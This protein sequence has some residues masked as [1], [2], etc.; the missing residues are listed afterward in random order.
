M[1]PPDKCRTFLPIII[2]GCLFLA[3]PVL[4]QISQIL[5]VAHTGKLY[6]DPDLGSPA[7]GQALTGAEAAVLKKVGDWYK[8]KVGELTGWLPREALHDS[9]KLLHGEPVQERKTEDV[10]IGVY[11]KKAGPAA[12]S[13]LLSPVARFLL[14]ER[15]KDAILRDCLGTAISVIPLACLPLRME[16]LKPQQAIYQDPDDTGSPLVQVPPDDQVELL[17]NVGDWFKVRYQQKTGWMPVK[18]FEK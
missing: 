8:V 10:L 5:K 6:Q 17:K 3:L 4:A 18:A 7:L 12:P 2:I 15:S 16:V 11:G 1:R 9:S 14:W 13:R